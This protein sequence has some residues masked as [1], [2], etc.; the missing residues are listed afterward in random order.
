MKMRN[1]LF[2]IIGVGLI[3][4]LFL[5]C[6]GGDS[7][8]VPLGDYSGGSAVNITTETAD[9][10]AN[11]AARALPGCVYSSDNTLATPKFQI[12]D[13]LYKST[14][15]EVFH[16]E[17]AVTYRS[18]TAINERKEG[19]CGGYYTKIGTHENGVDDLTYTYESYC[20][21][22]DLESTTV[23]GVS[24]V[25]NVGIPS[26]DGPIPQYVLVSN[27]DMSIVEKNSDGTFT[28]TIEGTTVKNTIG[29]GKSDATASN[30]NVLEVD[31]FV[32][33]DGKTGE[34]FSV[35]N[36]HITSYNS[37][38]DSVTII[39]DLTYTDPETGSVHISTT[40]M[41]SDNGV[42]TSGSITV[43]GTDGSTMVM[44]PDPSVEN[45]YG[46]VVDGETIGVMN[47]SELNS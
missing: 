44:T 41:Y 27:G 31:S 25:K 32:I 46:V 23:T 13:R 24:H 21:G 35:K 34:R 40:P 14:I 30:P 6:G 20:T 47:C 17:K 45:G 4:T 15:N 3:S 42:S 9:D 18:S 28:H 26:P 43:T 37:G 5:G 19:K 2:S 7:S 11:S 39:D 38:D 36:A 29:N 1:S 10:L 12:S 16:N 33:V 8:A 22:D